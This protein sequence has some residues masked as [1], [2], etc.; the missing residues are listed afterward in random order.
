MIT[1]IFV[2]LELFV[3]SL[4]SLEQVIMFSCQHSSQ[5]NITDNFP[6]MRASMRY[7][8][9]SGDILFDNLMCQ[10][11]ESSLFDCPPNEIFD[12]NCDHSEDA[13][14]VCNGM[15]VSLQMFCVTHVNVV[16]SI[17]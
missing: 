2:M 1:G 14:I 12:S 4:I 5:T 3:G 17:M 13:G 9:G 7:G 15:C 6:I 16:H 10:G 11:N 8:N